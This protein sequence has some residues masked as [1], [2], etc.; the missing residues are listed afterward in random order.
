MD[1]ETLFKEIGNDDAVEKMLDEMM[2]E[3][4]VAYVMKSQLADVL[5]NLVEVMEMKGDKECFMG[6]NFNDYQFT[7]KC[8]KK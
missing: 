8:E 6:F 5:H 7:I 2:D 4:M 3:L 1:I